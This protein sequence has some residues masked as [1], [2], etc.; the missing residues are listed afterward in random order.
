M[1]CPAPEFALLLAVGA[2]PAAAADFPPVDKL[3]AQAGLPDPLVMFDGAKVTTKEQWEQQR[4]PELKQLFQH[5]MYGYL[6]PPPAKVSY[7]VERED[8]AALNGKATLKEISIDVGMNVPPFQLLLLVPNQRKGPVPA[9]IGLNFGGNAKVLSEPE[10]WSPDQIIE[11]GY[12]LATMHRDN[13]SPDN[14]KSADHLW[15]KFGNQGAERSATDWATITAWVWGLQ[16]GLDYL[17][18]NKDIDPKRIAV[19]GHSRLGKTA[20]LAAALDERFALAI[21]SQAGCGGTA[22]SRGKV[23]E[24]VT[25][26]NTSFPHW[27]NGN[28]KRFN[29]S[30]ERLPFDQHCL[31]AL[32]APRPVLFSNAVEDTWA[33]PVGQFEVLQAAD[34]VYRFLGAG[35]LDARQQPEPGKLIDSKLGYYIRPG[36]HSMTRADWKVFLDYADK[37]MK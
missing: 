19:V 21:P 37:Q 14:A 25:R 12:A 30:T 27:F 17:L 23:G 34:P 36:K 11:R 7:K 8:K 35:G 24:S 6:P 33:N 22:P 1:R 18:T 31:A 5:Y 13:V 29:D 10:T 32:V 3:P 20:L 28:F 15:L 2:L 9:F 26:I 16:R 4:R